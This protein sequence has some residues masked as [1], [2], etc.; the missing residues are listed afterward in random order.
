MLVNKYNIFLFNLW[1]SWS[2]IMLS[3]FP[4][5]AILYQEDDVRVKEE[6]EPAA[7]TQL[8]HSSTLEQEV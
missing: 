8:A 4:P 2:P 1:L 3:L 5:S 7:L 6:E